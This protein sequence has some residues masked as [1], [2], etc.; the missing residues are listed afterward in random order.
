M[1]I[2]FKIHLTQFGGKIKH[3]TT[4]TL[5]IEPRINTNEER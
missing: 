5:F 4:L 1:T 2:F 3:L